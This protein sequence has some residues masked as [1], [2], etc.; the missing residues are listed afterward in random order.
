MTGTAETEAEEFG[1]IYNLDVVVLPTNV[2]Y[3]A[4]QGELT[5]ET[6][7]EDGTE[8]TTYQNPDNGQLYYKRV[9]YP[10]VVYKNPLAKFRAIVQELKEW[11]E[12]GRPVL[13]GT[14][15]IAAALARRKAEQLY[16]QRRGQP[17]C[18]LCLAD[19]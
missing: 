13:V 1:S 11:Q 14:I 9:D 18:A 5:K 3:R 10:D 4:L 15:L 8:I 17:V 19:G 6:H 7:K 16:R 2:E 12:L